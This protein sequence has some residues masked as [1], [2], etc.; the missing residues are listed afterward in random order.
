MKN[1][2]VTMR[3]FG[4]PEVLVFKESPSPSLGPQEFLLAGEFASVSTA[5][6]RIRS[7]NVPRGFGIIMSFLFGF[8]R[9]RFES[10]GTDYVGRVVQLGTSMPEV[11]KGDRVVVDLGMGLN[12][13]RTFRTIKPKDLW[14]KVP[15]SV[16]SDWAVASVFGGLT[17]LLFLRDKLKVQAKDRVLVIGAGG[18]V[19]SSA[20]QLAQHFGA[21]VIGVCSAEKAE[22]VKNLGASQV[23]DYKKQGWEGLAGKFDVVLDCVGVLDIASARSFLKPKGRAGFIVAD[24]LLNLKCVVFSLFEPFVFS[25]GAIQATRQDLQLLMELIV[26]G[27]F[28]PLIGR[29]FPFHEVVKAYREVESGHRLGTTLLDLSLLPP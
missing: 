7:K 12:G 6:V 17:A 21:D 14:V 15:E 8:R 22:V 11:K 29:R 19:G 3:S 27:E 24:V 18:A 13:Y 25:A 4:P 10:L 16:P 23:F 20:V 28:K 26:K 5:D 2:I 1:L 9:P